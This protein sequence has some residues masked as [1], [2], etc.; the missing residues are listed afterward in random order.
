MSGYFERIHAF[1]DAQASQ[2]PDLRTY[3]DVFGD[4]FSRKC[5]PDG[6]GGARAG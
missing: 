4:L 5:V 1:L 3:Y 6:M 2:D